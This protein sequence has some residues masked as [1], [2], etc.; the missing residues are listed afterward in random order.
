MNTFTRDTSH[1]D[2]KIDPTRTAIIVNSVDGR[3]DILL[4]Q[5]IDVRFPVDCLFMPGPD[6]QREQL[7]V[8]RNR[9]MEE[10]VLRSSDR[11]QHFV[12]FDDDLKP[13]WRTDL[14]FK[15]AGD[16]VGCE[17]PLESNVAWLRPD[18]VHLS[19][20]RFTRDVAKTLKAPYFKFAYNDNV[21][22]CLSCECTHFRD[23][24]LAAGFRVVRAGLAEHGNLRR[25]SCT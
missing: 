3:L 10:L 20:V 17:Y 5:Y 25:W 15:T 14:M 21:T 13:D 19:C 7:V 18:D 22:R 4:R 9:V 1:D 16:V 2:W 8:A 12:F 11:F 6:F 23:S 24:C